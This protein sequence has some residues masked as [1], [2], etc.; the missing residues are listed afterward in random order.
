MGKF[1]ID[2]DLYIPVNGDRQN[3]HIRSHDP[4]NPVLL[5]VHGGPGVSDRCFV[6]PN[7]TK[8][9]ADS[10]TMVCWDQRMSGKSYRRAKAE[11]RMTLDQQ[12]ED[13]NAVVLY[14]CERF[15]KEKIILIGHSWGSILC[16]LY[17]PKYSEHIE[18][19]VG[20]GQFVNGE[21]NE[22]L[23]YDFVYRYAKEHGDAKALRDLDR[24]GRPVDGWYPGGIDDLMVQR[25][26][27]TKYGGGTYKGKKSNI[28]V[29]V[30]LPFLKSGEYH[31]IPDLYRYAKG[32]FYCL[33]QLWPQVVKLKYDETLK[34]LPVPVLIFQGDHD[35][36]TPTE[37]ARAWF[38]ALQAP[39]KVWVGFH[40]SAHSPINEEPERWAHNLKRELKKLERKEKA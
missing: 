36:N 28:I 35:K 20:M 25:N 31:L 21:K 11:Q 40:E 14:L 2:E 18:A 22:N 33:R 17:L 19:Y 34:E 30:L 13:L 15:H 7:Q 8:Y 6:M 37:L 16:C 23:S 3:L 32:S 5:F 1:S 26:Y 10:F 29:G 27:M 38:D 24:I 9:L 12:V 4:E 39:Y